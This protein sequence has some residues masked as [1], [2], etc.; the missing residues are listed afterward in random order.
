MEIM[1]EDAN[2]GAAGVKATACRIPDRRGPVLPGPPAALDQSATAACAKARKGSSRMI[3][4]PEI[5]A[6]EGEIGRSAEAEL[7]EPPPRSPARPAIP[8]PDRGEESVSRGRAARHRAV[9]RS[10]AI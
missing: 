5:T 8:D 3:A 4:A 9:A 7:S 10:C 6:T 2:F 1:A